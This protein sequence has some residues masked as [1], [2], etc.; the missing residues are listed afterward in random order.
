MFIDGFVHQLPDI[1]PTETTEW[2]DSLDAVVEG[3]GRSRARVPAGPPHGARARPGRRR[4]RD[5]HHRLHQHRPARPGAVVPRRRGARAT[6]PG[7]DPVEHDGDGRP[8]QR[9]LRGSRRSPLDVRLGR[10][11]LRRR[12][13][14]LL[15]GQERRRLRRPDLHPGPRR[16]RHLRPR[17]PRRAALGRAA[18]PLPARGRRWGTPELSASAAPARLLGVPDGVDG[19]GPAERG[20]PG[21]V[22]P[23]L[24]APRGRRHERVEGVVLPGRR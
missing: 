11:A 13:Q 17:V 15:E 21:A 9:P 7:G 6:D 3:R 10:R 23:L 14:P 5:G 1:D 16:A 2:L 22:Q 19:A 20:V 4:P 18:R 24:A 8:R 12:L